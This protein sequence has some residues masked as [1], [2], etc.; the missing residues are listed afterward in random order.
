MKSSRRHRRA[1]STT[2]SSGAPYSKMRAVRPMRC[3]VGSRA[4]KLD[5][6]PDARRFDSGR[7]WC[8]L[9]PGSPLLGRWI[10]GIFDGLACV[11]SHSLAGCDLDGLYALWIPPFPCRSRRHT[12]NAK[13][14]DTDRIPGDEGI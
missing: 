11:E 7:R 3:S 13:S 4:V 12:E 10:E 9:L 5:R 14:G 2:S 6:S 8:S 1:T